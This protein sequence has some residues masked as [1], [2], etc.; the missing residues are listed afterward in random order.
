MLE[1]GVRAGV[2]HGLLVH[3]SPPL[4]TMEKMSITNW[5]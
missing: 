4:L 3:R 5:S 2:V 1:R